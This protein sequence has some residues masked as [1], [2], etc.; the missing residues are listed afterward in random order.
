MVTPEGGGQPWNVE[1]HPECIF[2]H[3]TVKVQEENITIFLPPKALVHHSLWQRSPVAEEDAIKETL[4]SNMVG[5]DIAAKSRV[6]CPFRTLPIFCKTSEILP[7]ASLPASH[8]AIKWQK[9]RPRRSLTGLYLINLYNPLGSISGAVLT[10]GRR[11]PKRRE[12]GRKVSK[13]A[14]SPFYPLLQK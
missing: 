2:R 8:N 14:F 4:L 13:R 3:G 10:S 1:P 6:K 7:S 11:G 5:V 9:S 12:M